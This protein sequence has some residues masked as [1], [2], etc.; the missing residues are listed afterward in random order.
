MLPVDDLRVAAA[1]ALEQDPAGALS[2]APG[3]YR[4]GAGFGWC[5]ALA[6]RAAAGRL[7]ARGGGGTGLGTGK[8]SGPGRPGPVQVVHRD[9]ARIAGAERVAAAG[10]AGFL[11]AVAVLGVLGGRRLRARR[12]A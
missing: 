3:G 11:A 4:P 7:A 2:Y 9:A 1:A 5:D 6:G 12:R 8:R 10:A